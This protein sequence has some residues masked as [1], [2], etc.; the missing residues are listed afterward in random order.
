MTAT[1]PAKPFIGYGGPTSANTNNRSIQEGFLIIAHTLWKNPQFGA[2]VLNSDSSYT[3][4]D[5]W[6]HRLTAPKNAHMFMQKI[7]SEIRA[8]VNSTSTFV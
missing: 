4:R 7:R 2:L 3:T 8:A 5:P 6:A 1:T